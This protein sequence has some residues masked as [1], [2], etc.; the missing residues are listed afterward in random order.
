M[1]ARPGE[2]STSARRV[3]DKAQARRLVAAMLD[4]SEP[5]LKVRELKKELVISNPRDPDKGRVYVDY[6]TG[7]VSWVRPVWD[8]WGPLQGYS[9]EDDNA[10][11]PVSADQIIDTLTGHLREPGDFP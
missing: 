2:P 10:G 7:F 1:T 8:H 5:E 11:K 3:I 9:G 4:G 6:E